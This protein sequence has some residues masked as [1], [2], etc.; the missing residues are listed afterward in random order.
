MNIQHPVRFASRLLFLALSLFACLSAK[1]TVSLSWNNINNLAV[2]TISTN[3]TAILSGPYRLRAKFIDGSPGGYHAATANQ[4]NNTPLNSVIAYGTYSVSLY[5]VTYTDYTYT[6]VAAIGPETIV[7]VFA[8]DTFVIWAT[9][10]TWDCRAYDP[11]SGLSYYFVSASGSPG[12]SSNA[13]AFSGTTQWAVTGT[14]ATTSYTSTTYFQA[15]IGSQTTVAAN[16]GYYQVAG[17]PYT[18]GSGSKVLH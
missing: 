18:V 9:S 15:A 8:N 5:S 4:N 14:H 1:A 13:N 16:N 11:Q 7:S 17:V 3:E 2:P 6:T 12:L 10:T